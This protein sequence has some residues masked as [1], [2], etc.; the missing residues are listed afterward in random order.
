ITEGEYQKIREILSK[1]REQYCNLKV[2]PR[3]FLQGLLVCSNC[4]RNITVASSKKSYYIDGKRY[5][6]EKNLEY[7]V[8]RCRNCRK[9]KGCNVKE[10]EKIIEIT[11]SQIGNQINDKIVQLKKLN[12]KE[13]T[14]KSIAK[15]KDL[16]KS[17]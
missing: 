17:I 6:D 7:Y 15:R 12:Q 14:A 2:N 13:I 1:R 11:I 10:V 4:G 9:N 16:E 3:H 5:Y 8:R